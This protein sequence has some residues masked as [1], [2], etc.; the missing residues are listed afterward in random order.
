MSTLT[1]SQ[2][3]QSSRIGADRRPSLAR[4]TAVELRKMVDTR[5][6]FWVLIGIGAVTLI[7]ALIE[8]VHDRGREGTYINV[9]HVASQPSAY[10][11]P[12]LGVLLICG[13][14]TQRTTLTT[15]TLVPERHRVISAKVLASLLVS[16]GALVLTLLG[17]VVLAALFGHAP[18]G[19]G[20]LPVAVIAQGWL[21][22][23]IWMLIG[24]SFGA[25]VLVSAPAIVAYLLAPIVFAAI[26]NAIH[27]LATPAKWLDVANAT[28]PLTLRALSATEWAQVGTTLALWLGVPLLIGLGR[29]RGGDIN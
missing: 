1:I 20:T 11:L 16:G 25:A 22:L 9:F 3:A 17:A 2:P 24:L 7:S 29:V 21:H 27:S 12:V 6:G 23:A 10:L 14:W 28:A 19:A 4:L 8:A 26:V 15:F 13:E 18:G 5:S